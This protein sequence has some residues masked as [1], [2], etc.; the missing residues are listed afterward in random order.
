MVP[1]GAV[2]PMWWRLY[3][4][5]DGCATLVFRVA[6]VQAEEV[7]PGVQEIMPGCATWCVGVMQLIGPGEGVAG[8]GQRLALRLRSHVT[9][10]AAVV[11]LMQ[12]S[13]ALR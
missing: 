2:V 12:A 10:Y 13:C 7:P 5:H 6:P 4:P 8:R 11:V 3:I 1:P 9:A